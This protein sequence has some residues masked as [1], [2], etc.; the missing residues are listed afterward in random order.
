ML[1]LS[2]RNSEKKRRKELQMTWL[3]AAEVQLGLG[4]QIVRWCT[5]QCPVR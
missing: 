3:G 5:G 1:Y 2:A 4:H